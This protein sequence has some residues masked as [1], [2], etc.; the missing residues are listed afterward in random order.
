VTPATLSAASP[1]GEAPGDVD[2]LPEP[3]EMQRSWRA[4]RDLVVVALLVLVL[5][6]LLEVTPAQDG[7]TLFGWR[8][9][10]SC[11]TQRYLGYGCPGCGLTR[12]FILGLRGELG[13]A[14][15]LNAVGPLL[16]LTLMVQLP[17]RG[18]RL[19]RHRRLRREGLVDLSLARGARWWWSYRMG[20]IAAL[21]VAWIVRL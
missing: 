3:P 13:A 14:Y 4:D 17:Y 8:L 19:L 5:G 1:V 20:L 10:E 16:L 12:S 6:L 9:P 21:L 2:E 15:R 7:V 18:L 11:A